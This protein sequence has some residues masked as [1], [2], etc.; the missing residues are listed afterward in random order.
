MT[1]SSTPFDRRFQRG[2]AIIMAMLVVAI[3][4]TV[5]SGVFYRQS[6]IAR[7]VENV[8]ASAQTRWLMAGAVDW[9][10]VILR[11]DARA[12]STDHLAE[13]WAVPLAQT[14]LNND[15]RDPVWL[16]GS[17]QD[18]Q[19]RFNLRNLVGTQVPEPSEVAVLERLL[20]VIGENRALASPLSLVVQE[21][22]MQPD[23]GATEL[24]VYPATIKD[25]VVEDPVLRETFDKLAPYVTILPTPTPVN[26]NTASAEVLAAR[27]EDLTLVDARRLTASRDTA[28]FRDVTD[29]LSRLGDVQPSVPAGKIAVASRFFVLDGT[30]EFRRARLR[31]QALLRRELG[32]VDVV[33]LREDLA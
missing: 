19:A 30:I 14:R 1:R 8:T 16:T 18:A 10:R 26:V 6:V 2:A 28:S 12:S 13:P 33:W 23:P 3:V 7:T 9:I 29:A 27:F 11:E 32:R 17:I 24:R 4:T 5:V 15:E 20:D 21:A 25:L 22:F 31:E